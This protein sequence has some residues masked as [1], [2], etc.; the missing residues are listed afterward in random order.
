MTEC[1]KVYLKDRWLIITNDE[2][3]EVSRV[4]E[5]EG[6]KRGGF[7]LSGHNNEML[8]FSLFK[9]SITAGLRRK[10][11]DI[12][13]NKRESDIDEHKYVEVDRFISSEIEKY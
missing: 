1:L 4:I 11:E 8:I 3:D 13:R 2:I 6:I 10:I 5:K 12:F 9:G 7:M